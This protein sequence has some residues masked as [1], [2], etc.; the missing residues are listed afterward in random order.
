M[1]FGRKY[2]AT[3]AGIGGW[4]SLKPLGVGSPS[5]VDWLRGWL[6]DVE[7]FWTDQLQAFKVHAE[8]KGRRPR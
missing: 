3:A 4:R 7:G 1:P 2:C 8:A 6:D 5:P